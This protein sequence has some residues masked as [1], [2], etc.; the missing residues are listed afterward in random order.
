MKI[1]KNQIKKPDP[2]DA[3]KKRSKNLEQYE[4]DNPPQ[5][6]NN[7]VMVTEQVFISDENTAYDPNFIKQ[8]CISH[9]LNLNPDAIAN[10]FDPNRLRDAKVQQKFKEL[11]GLSKAGY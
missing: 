11:P 6:D 7:T 2:N 5:K 9:I 1:N 4:V 3:T 10:V 8:N